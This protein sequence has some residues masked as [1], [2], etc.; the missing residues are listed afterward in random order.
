MASTIKFAPAL[1]AGNTFVLKP[2]EDTSL[3]ACKLGEFFIEAGFPD[4]V[5]N[6]VTGY[7]YEIGDALVSHPSVDWVGFTGSTATGKNILKNCGLKRND[8]E[9]GGKSPC[10]V[11]D[12]ANL[13]DAVRNAVDAIFMF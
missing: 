13:D 8:L 12:D 3:S 7:G 4:G 6:I 2:A 1:A 9:M 10:I 11:M 5:M